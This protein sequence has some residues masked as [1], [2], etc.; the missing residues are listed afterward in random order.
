MTF[1]F[2]SHPIK[3][4]FLPCLP[5]WTGFLG[6]WEILF[7]IIFSLQGLLVSEVCSPSPQL[8]VTSLVTM[9]TVPWWSLFR[10][11]SLE[12]ELIEDGLSLVILEP[13][14]QHSA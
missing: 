9:A 4:F 14:C 3:I 6:W 13:C 11:P 8:S 5:L 12:W 1:W 7:L 2:N 10:F